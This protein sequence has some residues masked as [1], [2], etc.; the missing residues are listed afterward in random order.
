M[1]EAITDA[2]VTVDNE[3]EQL[4]KSLAEADDSAFDLTAKTTS[5]PQVE[6]PDT[7]SAKV[8]DTPREE[9]PDQ[10]GE[11]KSQEI[12]EEEQSK[13]KYSRTKKAQDRANKSW[14]KSMKRKLN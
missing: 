5:M 11:E 13:S 12:E 3:R 9:T 4:L 14:R 8:E 6:E 7:E 10:P 2:P 1:S